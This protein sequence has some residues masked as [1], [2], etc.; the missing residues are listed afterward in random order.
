MTYLVNPM[1]AL[2]GVFVSLTVSAG[3][4][5]TPQDPDPTD[6]C[7]GCEADQ[8]VRLYTWKHNGTKWTWEGGTGVI[9]FTPSTVADEDGTCE[10]PSTGPGCDD[11]GCDSHIK[12]TVTGIPGFLR[13]SHGSSGCVTFAAMKDADKSLN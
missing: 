3:V 6:T 7:T 4:L 2:L 8:N 10:T 12:A 13:A 9:S 11:D 1:A 5:P